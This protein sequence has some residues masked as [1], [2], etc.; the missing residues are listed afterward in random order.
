MVRPQSPDKRHDEGGERD[1]ADDGQYAIGAEPARVEQRES[2]R[3]LHGEADAGGQRPSVQLVL[4]T[5]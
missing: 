5:K 4:D 3:R 1:D 2:R